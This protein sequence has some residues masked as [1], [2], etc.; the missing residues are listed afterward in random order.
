MADNCER[1][2]S[3]AACAFDHQAPPEGHPEWSVH[4]V[5]YGALSSRH[6]LL[7]KEERIEPQKDLYICNDC[8]YYVRLDGRESLLDYG[9]CISPKSPYDGQV[10]MVRCTCDAYFG[11]VRP[12]PP[13]APAPG[14][15]SP[16]PL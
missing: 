10:V 11:V 6:S 7:Q 3:A 4:L 5:G 12:P 16:S 9:V 13:A 14:P 8:E 15:L 2:S 1:L